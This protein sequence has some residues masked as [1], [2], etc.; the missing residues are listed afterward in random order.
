MMHKSLFHPIRKGAIFGAIGGFVGGVIMYIIMSEVMLAI[1][2]GANCFAVILG[3]ITGQPISNNLVPLGIVI[4]L[5]TS[6]LIGAIFGIVT[7]GINKL[8]ITGY[9]KGIIFGVATGLIAFVIL[10]LP[11]AMVLMPPKMSDLMMT[12]PMPEN[13]NTMMPGSNNN[14]G[15]NG[16]MMTMPMLDAQKMQSIIIEGSLLGH[17]IY[18]LILGFIATILWKKTRA[19]ALEGEKVSK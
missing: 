8:Q 11:I 1:G 14:S 13:K 19:S 6:T 7:G 2:M 12:M 16:Q 10:F 15:M 5:I 3:L 9:A 18:G 17:L 4:H